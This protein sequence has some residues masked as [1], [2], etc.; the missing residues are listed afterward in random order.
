MKIVMTN[1]PWE[2]MQVGS[3]RRATIQKDIFWVKEVKGDYGIC[4]K[5]CDDK[6]IPEQEIKLKDIEVLKGK[7]LRN[8]NFQWE[9]ILRN[10]EHWETFKA[11]CDNLIEVAHGTD[12]EK[13]MVVRVENRLRHWQRLMKNSIN[14]K[15]SKE[16]QMGL[17]T[18]LLFLKDELA[19]KYG[20][21]KAIQLWGGP[22]SDKQDFLT[23]NAAIEIKSFSTSKGKL[24]NISSKQQLSSSKD[25]LYL[26]A[27]GISNSDKGKSIYD[28]VCEITNRLGETT[29]QDIIET[30]EFKL[31]EYGYSPILFKE[32]ELEKFKV[33]S[34]SVYSVE[35]RFPRIIAENVPVEIVKLNY[36]I[37]LT[38][39]PNK[40]EIEKII[41]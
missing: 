12:N 13:A 23:D 20:L 11:L 19:S 17:F 31:Y 8:N 35:N 36:Q 9:L 1:N 37:D 14:I 32:N 30:L 34:C 29:D 25:N 10:K 39:C 38:V 27:Y 3:E 2:D 26:V 16:I 18:E 5:I 40:I 15:L 6:V 4:I 33:D 22:N 24:I 41:Y 21:S 7:N 28:L